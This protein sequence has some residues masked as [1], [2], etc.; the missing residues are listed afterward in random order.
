[1]TQGPGANLGVS[2]SIMLPTK[3]SL[4]DVI[5]RVG[6]LPPGLRSHMIH[7]I[8]FEHNSVGGAAV[9]PLN[10]VLI[11]GE[12]QDSVYMHEASHCIDRGFY[13]SETFRAAKEKDSCWP[14]HYSKSAD[15]ELFAEIGVLHLYDKS[16]K[17]LLERGHDPACLANGLKAIDEYVGLDYQ[18]D[19]TKCFKRKPNSKVVYPSEFQILSPEP[20]ISNAV[21]EDFSNPGQVSSLSSPASPWGD[22]PREIHGQ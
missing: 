18:R 4:D 15:I 14:T 2:M 22:Y 21:I 8:A 5:T 19:G 17:T 10:M 9:L 12:A 13:A 6:K 20:Y 3:T 1:M 11:F 7:L 16:G